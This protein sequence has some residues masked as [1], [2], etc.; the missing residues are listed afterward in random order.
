V[1]HLLPN[2]KDQFGAAGLEL[3]HGS[4]PGNKK[5]CRMR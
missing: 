1:K 4:F 5:A 3:R 2:G